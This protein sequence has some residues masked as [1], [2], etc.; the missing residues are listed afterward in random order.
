[1]ERSPDSR[2]AW[3]CKAS[4]VAR[5]LT[6][7]QT[8]CTVMYVTRQSSVRTVIGIAATQGWHHLHSANVDTA[9][10]LSP[11]SEDI[12]IKRPVCTTCPRTAT[13]LTSVIPA[14]LILN[15]PYKYVADQMVLKLEK[16]LYGLH[17]AP[18]NW[19]IL[20]HTY[21]IEQ[22]FVHCPTDPCLY[23]LDKV[24]RMTNGQSLLSTLTMLSLPLLMMPTHYWISDF[25]QS[26]HSR[27]GIKDQGETSW[28]LG[29]A[30][31]K[32]R[33]CASRYHQQS[34]P[35]VLYQGTCCSIRA[36]DCIPQ[37]PTHIP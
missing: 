15:S 2:L 31:N 1:M 34:L 6:M 12:F 5:V 11:I 13:R 22:G 14:N 24:T 7:T 30:V 33:Q 37:D 16:S 20:L 32:D 28:L 21:L 25:K 3:S 18:R 26:L 4:P 23:S 17:Q 36:P 35:G 10:L 9:F 29:V 27:F 19:Y 8:V